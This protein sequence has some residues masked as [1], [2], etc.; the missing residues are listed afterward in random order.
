MTALPAHVMLETYSVLTR[1]PAGLAVPPSTATDV[2]GSRF[3]D[4]VLRLDEADRA[5]VLETLAAA[6]VSGGAAYDG[7]VALE[8]R[9]H[10]QRLLSLDLRAQETYHRLGVAFQAI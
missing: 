4:G 10:E 3:G 9:A 8:A 6:R 7:L 1:L 5:G 2:L